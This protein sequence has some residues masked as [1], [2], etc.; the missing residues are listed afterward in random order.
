MVSLVSFCLSWFYL[1]NNID[2]E[3]YEMPIWKLHQQTFHKI[4]PKSWMIIFF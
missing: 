3:L 2:F 1:I 4:Y